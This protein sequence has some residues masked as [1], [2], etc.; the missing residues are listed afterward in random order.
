MVEYIII[1][2]CPVGTCGDCP[3]YDVCENHEKKRE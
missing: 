1:D 2:I 3:Y